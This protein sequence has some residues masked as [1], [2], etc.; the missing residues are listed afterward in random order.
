MTETP[1]LSCPTCG[2][3][4]SGSFCS[5]CG[6]SLVARSCTLCRAQLSPHARFC[7][8]CGRPVSAAGRPTSSNRNT[9]IIAGIVSL[10]MVVAITYKVSSAAPRAVVPD[11]ANAGGQ[12][13]DNQADGANSSGGQSVPIRAPDISSMS[14]RERF[15]RL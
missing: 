7:H 6:A 5:N 12:N 1:T 10:L 8:R 13:A 9:W 3:A 4:A 11:M 14:P 2:A 15:D